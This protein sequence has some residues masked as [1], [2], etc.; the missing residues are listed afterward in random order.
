[1][2]DGQPSTVIMYRGDLIL[3][4]IGPPCAQFCG[5]A[6]EVTHMGNI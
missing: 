6:E 1:M 4:T 2:G 3:A 5:V